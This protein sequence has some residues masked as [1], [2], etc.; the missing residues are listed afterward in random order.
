MQDLRR[1]HGAKGRP[2]LCHP[3]IHC[4]DLPSPKNLIPFISSGF[5]ASLSPHRKAPFVI[6]IRLSYRPSESR[7][8]NSLSNNF[9]SQR[10]F[11][12]AAPHCTYSC[13][14]AWTS[15]APVRNCRSSSMTFRFMLSAHDDTK[16]ENRVL[17]VTLHH[18]LFRMSAMHQTLLEGK[19][20]LFQYRSHDVPKGKSQSGAKSLAVSSRTRLPPVLLQPQ[21]V[22]NDCAADDCC[23]FGLQHCLPKRDQGESAFPGRCQFFIRPA[24][25]RTDQIE[26][27]RAGEGRF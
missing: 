19:T 9:R 1:Q 21:F 25:L 10:L 8:L 4:P 12:Q 26:H 7:C 6:R 11:A 18:L 2:S 24:A 20:T 13:G 5:A 23:G 16:T 17:P 3:H 22:S 15:F 27:R 14:L